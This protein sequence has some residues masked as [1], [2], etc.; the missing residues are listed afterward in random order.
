MRSS[1]QVDQRRAKP[2]RAAPQRGRPVGRVKQAIQPRAKTN[3]APSL[4]RRPTGPA[5]SQPE[6]GIRQDSDHPLIQAI[7]DAVNRA[8]TDRDSDDTVIQAT[9]EAIRSIGFALDDA[10]YAIGYH[11]YDTEPEKSVGP[12][13]NAKEHLRY[14]IEM[15]DEAISIERSA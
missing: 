15:I 1:K 10:V 13:A 4:G 8:P 5:Q 3:R 2:S 9:S 6:L 7:S 12:L 11:L 14:A